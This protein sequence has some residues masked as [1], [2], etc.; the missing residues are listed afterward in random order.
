MK[1]NPIKRNKILAVL[2][3]ALSFG[4]TVQAQEKPAEKAIS[5]YDYTAV[6]G[7]N[8]Y[9]KNSTPTHSASGQPGAKYWQ[10]KADYQLTA[11]LN[12]KN[13][14]IIGSEILTY[15]NN[16]PDKISFLWLNVDQ[17]LFEK[18]SRGMATTP[19]RGSRN[20]SNGQVFDGGHKIKSVKI[21]T[22]KRG[23]L[24]ETAAQFEITDTRMQVFLP[25]DLDSDGGTVSLKIEFSFISPNFGADRM[26]VLE[27]KNG[28]IF[29]IAQWYPTMCVYDDV[30]GWNTM[31]Y[32]GAGEFYM[33][34]GDFE[35]NITA[36]ANHIVVCSGELMNPSEVYTPE[37][38]KRWA[39][40]L[41][42]DNTVMIRSSEEILNPASRP[43]GKSTLTWRFKMTNSRDVSWASSTAFIVDAAK[44]NLPSGK[45]SLAISAYPIESSG[46]KAWGRSTEYTK[47]SIENYSKRWF[48]YPYPAAINVAGIAGGMEYPGIVFCNYEMKGQELW[49]VTD[50][51][52]GHIW[53]P[54]IV[55]SNERQF[56]WMDEG[57]NTFINTLS[58]VDFNKGEYKSRVKNMH[59]MAKVFTN[60][61]LE[62][63]MT[64]PDGL[65]NRNL[66]ILAYEKPSS[67]LVMLREQVLGT[68]KFDRA[69]RIY[70]ARWAFKHPTPDDFFRTMENAAGEN[71]NWFWRGWFVNNWRLDQGI[72]KVEY[73]QNDP[74]L[75]AIITIENLE[76]MAMPVTVEI[77]TKS[78]A[79]SRMQ[80]PVEIWQRTATWSF[81]NAATEEIESITLDPD[82]VLPDSDSAN[83]VWNAEKSEVKKGVALT[84]YLGN[85]SS[86]QIPLKIAFTENNGTLVGTPEGDSGLSFDS[87]GKDR[88][89][90]EQAGIEIQFT[91]SKKEFTLK[92]NGQEF[93]FTR[94]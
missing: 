90:A 8:F 83:N 30:L 5:K 46:E 23:K 3:V 51:E 11:T 67:G 43:S 57:F 14:E 73:V 59:R 66:G 38:Q 4:M 92:M 39:A 44:I 25:E 17:N 65:K 93:F 69:F 49:E 68:E 32:L 42:S 24:T 87:I 29:T 21:L 9:T 60:P 45:K 40:A 26:G 47:T 58:S 91:E 54:M 10:N 13:N 55:G 50:H 36:P 31:P 86:K 64:I 15:T 72:T 89:G 85:Y 2:Y 33:E 79:V 27:T 7:P 74:K 22:K 75:G 41:Q 12:E 52:F 56:A 62:P 20:G 37:Q 1:N 80:L 35:V 70:I 19:V 77:K 84:G 18:G 28:K 81:K 6:F 82:H 94:V 76:K 61:E 78:G 48:E 88:F 63:I 34:Y 16:S 71:L 53:F